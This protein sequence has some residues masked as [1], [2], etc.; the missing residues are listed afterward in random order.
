MA[1]GGPFPPV[2]PGQ[3]VG[4]LPATRRSAVMVLVMVMQRRWGGGGFAELRY[5]DKIFHIPYHP[6]GSLFLLTYMSLVDVYGKSVRSIYL[7]SFHE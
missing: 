6:M 4:V 3:A 5:A 7:S 2:P 1:W